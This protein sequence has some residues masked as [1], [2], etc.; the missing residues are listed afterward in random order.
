[1]AVCQ[2]LQNVNFL[3]IHTELHMFSCFTYAVLNFCKRA[4]M[5]M[6]IAGNGIIQQHSVRTIAKKEKK[7]SIYA[8][9]QNNGRLACVV[10]RQN[11]EFLGF[12]NSSQRTNTLRTFV[13]FRTRFTRPVDPITTD[14]NETSQCVDIQTC[15]YHKTTHVLFFVLQ[16]SC[17]LVLT[18]NVTHENCN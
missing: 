4:T 1:M 9:S 15:T 11:H 3:H 8:V 5:A 12:D 16:L 6:S 18:V 14:G 2:S 10:R 17:S 7:R 13:H